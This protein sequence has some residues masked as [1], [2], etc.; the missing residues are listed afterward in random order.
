MRKHV[1]HLN[2]MQYISACFQHDGSPRVHR[3][4]QL[5]GYVHTL[6]R[7]HPPSECI[8]CTYGIFNCICLNATD[9]AVHLSQQLNTLLHICA[10][11]KHK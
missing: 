3:R 9:H 6:A 1:W 2:Q 10:R 7:G 8:A 11:L 5:C 4:S